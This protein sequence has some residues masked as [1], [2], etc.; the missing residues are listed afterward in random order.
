MKAANM[1]RAQRRRRER[2]TSAPPS[3]G[4]WVAAGV[5]ALLIAAILAIVIINQKAATTSALAAN[6][7]PL[8]IGEPAPPFDVTTIDGRRI[9]SAAIAGPIMIEI[10]ATWCPHCQ[11]ETEVLENLYR[12]VGNK[13][14]MIAVTGSGLA[15]DHK[16]P[17]SADDV[18]AFAK[19]FGVGYNVAD[20]PKLTVA[21]RYFQGGFPT[22]VFIN[23]KD[24]VAAIEQGET[25]LNRLLADARKAGVRVSPS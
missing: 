8:H 4:R 12:Q 14:A 20:D 18:R 17:E 11:R 25:P 19:Y 16:T 10:F 9:D 3:R 23:S 7:A 2:T 22:I 15:A 13:L 5:T 21:D 6:P 24:R 1:N